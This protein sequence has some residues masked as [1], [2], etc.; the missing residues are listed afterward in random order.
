VLSQALVSLGVTS[1]AYKGLATINK[2]LSR[3]ASEVFLSLKWFNTRD[4]PHLPS[5]QL[6][7]RHIRLFDYTASTTFIHTYR[8]EFG[9][10]SLCNNLTRL[11]L[12]GALPEEGIVLSST[13][14]DALRSLKH[15]KQLALRWNGLYSFDDKSFTL[16]TAFPQLQ[17]LDI[18]AKSSTA[19]QLFSD[20]LPNLTSL[21][22]D[23]GPY[24]LIPWSTLLSLEVCL[25]EG[26][27]DRDARCF[28]ASLEGAFKG[29]TVRLFYDSS[30]DHS[31]SSA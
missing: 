12:Q 14:S 17:E 4:L 10:L 28:V 22:V 31:D 20:P 1:E 3:I 13:F 24:H 9:V 8:L 25:V 30:S 16:G 15:L 5:R 7:H 21:F 23:A 2:R 18:T 6:L 29:N 19:D 11:L 27:G 26:E